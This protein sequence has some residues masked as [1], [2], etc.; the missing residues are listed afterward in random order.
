[1]GLKNLEQEESILETSLKS[2]TP[3][4]GLPIFHFISSYL[5]YFET[6]QPKAKY[7]YLI[8]TIG[9]DGV[10]LSLLEPKT[11]SIE[12]LFGSRRFLNLR[13]PKTSQSSEAEDLSVFRSRRP[14]RKPKI[15]QSLEAEDFSI[16]RSRRLL[17]LQGLKISLF[18]LYF[19]E[20]VY[21]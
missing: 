20:K 12:D 19:S 21:L 11:S 13:K 8:N 1:M 3:F 9:Q 16:F 10:D 18:T 2:T 5:E 17:N 15:S 14:L 4:D 6:P 7:A